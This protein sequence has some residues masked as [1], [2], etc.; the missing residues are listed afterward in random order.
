MRSIQG[1]NGGTLKLAEKGE[2]CNPH[3]RPPRMISTFIAELKAMGIEPVKPSQIV[4]TFEGL[5]NMKQEQ[6]KEIKDN[7]KNPY[8]LR[9]VAGEMM[10]SKG[11]EIIERM[12]DRAHGKPKQ[13]TD[14]TSGGEKIGVILPQIIIE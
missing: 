1:R 13:Q 14:I 7:E 5:I 2:V 3:G 11:Y 6:L 4:D 9:R 8:F 10:T 12:I